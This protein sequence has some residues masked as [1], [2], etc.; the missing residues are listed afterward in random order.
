MLREREVTLDRYPVKGRQGGTYALANL[1]AAC[2]DCNTRDGKNIAKG[3]IMNGLSPA[4][5]R[6][7]RRRQESEQVKTCLTRADVF[8]DEPAV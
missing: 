1:R 6:R 7:I 5:K 3:S 2:W 4:Q 8:G